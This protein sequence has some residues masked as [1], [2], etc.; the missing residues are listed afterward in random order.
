MSFTEIAIEMAQRIA[1]SRDCE[2][3][4]FSLDGVEITTDEETG[5]EVIRIQ[6]TAQ[7]SPARDEIPFDLDETAH[8]NPEPEPEAIPLAP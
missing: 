6:A 7:M 5:V 8:P 1:R 3:Q 4:N 2:L